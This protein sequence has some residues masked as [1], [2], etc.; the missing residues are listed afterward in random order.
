MEIRK[1]GV[2]GCGQ[3]GGGIARVCAH[4]GYP[5][6]VSELN[7]ALLQKGLA[8]IASSLDRDEKKGRITSSEKSAVLSRIG[9]TTQIANLKDCDIIIEAVVENL[10][11]KKQ[12]FNDFDKMCPGDNILATNTSSLSVSEIAAA[13]G[14]PERVLG[15]HFFNPVSS[16]KLLEIVRTKA[17][18]NAALETA[19]EFGRSL[20]KTVVITQDTPGFI[21]NRLMV[22]QLLTAIS[23]LESGAASKEDIDTAMTLGLNHPIGPLALADLVGL[24][25]LLNMADSIY[26]KLREPQYLAPPLLKNLVAAGRLGRKTGHGFY[27]Y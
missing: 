17:T 25:V 8:A 7:D 27:E 21:V 3:M 16:M 18:G 15:I 14:R 13:T 22:P 12:I 9:G 5:V 23:I 1:V 20:G 26:K 11:L 4:S 2:V 6:L 24:D 19:R 10:D